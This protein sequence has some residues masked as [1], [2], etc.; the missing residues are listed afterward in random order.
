V[1]HIVNDLEN[2]M[3]VYMRLDG[4]G[5]DLRLQVNWRAI[6]DFIKSADAFVRAAKATIFATLVWL[7]VRLVFGV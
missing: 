5:F 1:C 3:E 4:E 2:D 7:V 6:A